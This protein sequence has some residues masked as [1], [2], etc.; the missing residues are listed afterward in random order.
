MT[1]TVTT[2]KTTQPRRRLGK[3]KRTAARRVQPPRRIDV[4][5]VRAALEEIAAQEPD[6]RDP[7]VQDELPN[8][9][10]D[11]GRANCFVARVL[12]RLGYQTS[13]LKALDDE[14]RI[15]QP[16]HAGARIG[17]SRHPALAKLTPT[18]RRLLQYVQD[19]Q[20]SGQA[21]GRI[22]RDAFTAERWLLRRWVR[23]RK[24]WLFPDTA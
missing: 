2:T 8:R 12:L 3:T 24:P 16:F 1:T 9:Y 5:Q 21:W 23:E 6:Q 20:D 4:E 13:I 22:V 14:Y 11:R 15:G 19:A 7:R 17:E 10:L 18:A